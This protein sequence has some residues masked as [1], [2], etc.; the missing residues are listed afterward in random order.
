M[1]HNFKGFDKQMKIL[2]ISIEVTKTRYVQAELLIFSIIENKSKNAYFDNITQKGTQPTIL[3]LLLF[4]FISTILCKLCYG[5]IPFCLILSILKLHYI[6]WYSVEHTDKKLFQKKNFKLATILKFTYQF[7][8]LTSCH[9]HYPELLFM[10]IVLLVTVSF[11][12]GLEQCTPK[13]CTPVS[14]LEPHMSVWE[15]W[16]SSRLRWC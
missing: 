15:I 3:C 16:D 12:L 11:L 1:E 8:L 9:Y 7:F 13:V 14:P 10:W 5:L 2:M 4:I 6:S